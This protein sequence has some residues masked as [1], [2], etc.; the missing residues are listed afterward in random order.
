MKHMT[1][2]LP[3][4]KL[5]LPSIWPLITRNYHRCTHAISI[6]L[7]KAFFQIPVHPKAQHITCLKF[8]QDSPV[9][10][11]CYIDDAQKQLEYIKNFMNTKLFAMLDLNERIILSPMH[12]GIIFP[13]HSRRIY[14]HKTSQSPLQNTG[15]LRSS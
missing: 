9:T 6:D 2:F 11:T 7:K 5:S 14:I 13:M 12:Q 15:I 3:K 10:K 1:R 4:P 8:T